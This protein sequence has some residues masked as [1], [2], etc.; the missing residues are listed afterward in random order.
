MSPVLAASLVAVLTSLRSDASTD[1]AATSARRT[2]LAR[3]MAL[4]LLAAVDFGLEAWMKAS[5]LS[6]F[7][8]LVLYVLHS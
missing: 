3:D 6:T 5:T 8:A 4:H 1:R 7:S 2:S